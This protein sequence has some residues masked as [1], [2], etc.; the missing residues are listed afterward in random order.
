MLALALAG[1]V[2]MAAFTFSNYLDASSQLASKSQIISDQEREIQQQASTI[3]SQRLEAEAKSAELA[4]VQDRINVLTQ[5]LEENEK[6][7]GEQAE[8]VVGLKDQLDA[9][10]EQAATLDVEIAALQAKIQSDEQTIQ[11][12][13]RKQEAAS[14]GKIT[15]SHFGLGVDQNDVG[16]VFPIRVEIIQSGTG[17]LSV[18]INNV[19]YEPGFQAAVR[20]AAA[21]A[22]QYTGESIHDKDIIVRFAP[23]GAQQFGPEQIKVDGSSAGAIIAAMIAAGLSDAEISS[24]ILVTGSI[25]E[26]GSVG[27]VGGLEAKAV[28]AAEFGAEAMIVPESQEFESELVPVIG[29]SDIGELMQQ[30]GASSS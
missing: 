17:I 22:S 21:A 11:E 28:A 25:G 12:L 27:R 26:D 24:S 23:G 10:N 6:A 19:Q 20:A 7:L 30:L 2:A 15:V 29:V 1:A 8:V 16:M 5:Q 14:S 9:A 18:D 4:Q 3:E 13:T